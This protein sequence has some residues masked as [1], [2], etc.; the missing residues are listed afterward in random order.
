MSGL[1]IWLII[2]ISV[3]FA[4]PLAAVSAASGTSLGEYEAECDKNEV[5]VVEWG[6]NNQFNAIS[7]RNDSLA[8]CDLNF[9]AYYTHGHG[10]LGEGSQTLIGYATKLA[11][12]GETVTLVII[13]YNQSNK[14]CKVQLDATATQPGTPLASGGNDDE[15]EPS[16]NGGPFW[17]YPNP[18]TVGNQG[19]QYNSL[20]EAHNEGYIDECVVNTPT[21][22][23]T[24]TPT[25]T[26]TPTSTATPTKTA[27]PSSTPTKT[28]TVTTTP[29]VYFTPT[30]TV[31]T[32]STP[33]AT[34]TPTKTNPPGTP[35]LTKSPVSTGTTP[36]ANPTPVAPTTG[37]GPMSQEEVLFG[38]AACIVLLLTTMSLLHIVGSYKKGP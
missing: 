38:T 26:A 30:S 2:A 24:S 22:T 1:K 29:F 31:G 3:L 27:T 36:V 23:P 32:T 10:N 21:P 7:M 35:T 14:D 9:G 19:L 25:A 28:P 11:K 8:D 37:T 4:L 18:L 13:Q 17:V 20:V 16:Y 5:T 34:V 6:P 12:P 33:T 15:P